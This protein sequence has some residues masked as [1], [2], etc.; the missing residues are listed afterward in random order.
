V[1]T[2]TTPTPMDNCPGATASCTPAGGTA[3]AVGTTLAGRS[4]VLEFND[5]L[6]G[7]AWTGLPPVAGDGTVRT[8]SD[9]SASSL[10]RFYRVRVD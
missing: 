9:P 10:N 7:S 4:Y 6:D 1:V 3:F 8:L 5:A 2:Y